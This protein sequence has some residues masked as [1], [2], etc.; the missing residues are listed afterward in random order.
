MM[1]F[2]P[3]KTARRRLVRAL[4]W[5]LLGGAGILL[6]LLLLNELRRFRQTPPELA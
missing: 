6:L 5:G 3:L 2:F 1:R 4:K